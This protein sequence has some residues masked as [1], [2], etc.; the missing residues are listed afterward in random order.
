MA[1]KLLRS[2]S[3]EKSKGADGITTS[4]S[5]SFWEDSPV[6]PLNIGDEFQPIPNITSQNELPDDNYIY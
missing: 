1:E 5:F 3:L 6:S 4:G 2:H